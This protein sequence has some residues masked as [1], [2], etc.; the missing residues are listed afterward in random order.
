[1]PFVTPGV[2]APCE[3]YPYFVS[4]RSSFVEDYRHICGGVLISEETVLTAA[5]C[6]DGSTGHFVPIL[7]IDARNV[8]STGSNCQEQPEVRVSSNSQTSS[9]SASIV[10]QVR[11][12]AQIV[13]HPYW[14]RGESAQ[15][16]GNGYDLAVIKLNKPSSKKP[17]AIQGRGV[18]R[19]GDTLRFVGLGRQSMSSGFASVVQVGIMNVESEGACEADYGRSLPTNVLCTTRE[20]EYCRGDE[21][22]PLISSGADGD[23]LV[24]IAHLKDASDVCG[25]A[26]FAGLFT[27]AARLSWWIRRTQRAMQS[28]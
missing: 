21:G 25:L 15:D 4:V 17:I 2:D 13:I 9:Q 10:G 20:R 23:E 12:A 3:R 1:M 19:T 8:E 6:V 26:D 27:N 18:V 11:K 7:V 28:R 22:G 24:A 5:H 14:F 16:L